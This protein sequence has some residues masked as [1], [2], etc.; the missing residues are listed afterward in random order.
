MSEY[1]FQ[2]FPVLDSV[3]KYASE[4]DW[5]ISSE[6]MKIHQKHPRGNK[7]IEEYLLRNFRKPKNFD[8]NFY[9]ILHKGFPNWQ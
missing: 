9:H 4:A 6:V 8:A 5:D 3:K 7:I 2:S 1:G